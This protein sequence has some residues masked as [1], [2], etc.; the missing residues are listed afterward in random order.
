MQE[1]SLSVYNIASL[2]VFCLSAFQVAG[3]TMTGCVGDMFLCTEWR[4]FPTMDR[5]NLTEENAKAADS[6]GMP[7][8]NCAYVTSEQ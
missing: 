7:V 5:A 4:T 6:N 2:L 3:S 1:E 8:Q